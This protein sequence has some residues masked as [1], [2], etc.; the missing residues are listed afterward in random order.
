[1]IDPEE[2]SMMRQ[3]IDEARRVEEEILGLD[4]E[5][6]KEDKNGIAPRFVAD[7]FRL[8]ERGDAKLF[9]AVHRNRLI[10]V[11]KFSAWLYWAGNHWKLDEEDR[12]VNAVDEVA[13]YYES[14]AAKLKDRI[15]ELTKADHKAEAKLLSE[16]MQKYK[17]RINK[18]RTLKGAKICAEYSH[19]IGKESLSIIGPELDKKPM[20]LACPNAVINL[21]TGEIVESQPQDYILNAANTEWK[22]INEPCPEWEKFFASIHEGDEELMRLVHTMLGYSTTGLRTEHFIGCFIGEGRN[23]KGT[24]FETLRAILGD[25]GWTISPEMLLEQKFNRSSAGPSPDLF[26]LMGRRLV[27]AS[28]TDDNARISASQVKRLTGGDTIKTRAPHATRE[29]NFTATHKLFLYSQYAPHGLAKDYALYKRLLF[30][31]YVLKFVDNPKEPNERQRDPTLPEKFEAE[32]SGILAWLVRGALI[33]KAEGGLH[34]PAKVQA[35][36][37]AQRLQDDVILQFFQDSLEK[38]EPD[39]YLKF[40]DLYTKFKEF[41][42]NS[43]AEDLRYLPS[44]KKFSKWFADHEYKPDK[45]G[46]D[47]IIYGITLKPIDC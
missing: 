13:K 43:V 14:Y 40:S 15:D 7:C 26:S 25:L 9:A 8:N 33:W 16:L 4:G 21:A 31:N 41:Y 19:Q 17:A 47:A 39:I 6:D 42:S 28:E 22:G 32:A 37:D 2:L 38:A 11:K 30:I 10:Y 35:S 46:G 5:N 18:L 3:K 29:I 44:K 1:M 36:I 24:M 23:G 34:P 20:L 45:K 27:I 12:F